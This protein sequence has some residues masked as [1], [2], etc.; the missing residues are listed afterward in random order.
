[1]AI[2]GAVI[3]AAAPIASADSIQLGSFATGTVAPTG[4]L[5]T[6]MNYA[7]V[8]ASTTPTS[9]TGASYTLAPGTVW[10]APLPNS[11]WVGYAS[12]AY[13]GGV[14]P[15]YGYYTFTTLFS[16]AGGTYSG[17]IDVMA[18]DTA[19]VLLNGNVIVPFGALGSDSHCA[20]GQ[21]D[22]LAIDPMALTGILL[23]SGT[24][25]NVLTFVVQQ[26]GLEGTTVDPSG[27]DFDATL[28]TSVTTVPEPNSLDLLGTGLLGSAAMLWL[29]RRNV[30]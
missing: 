25:N 5:N 20:G 7:G 29:F 9:G 19:E 22:C 2:L 14:N 13:P 28:A 27:V 1:L 3:A 11:A 10:S 23:N 4:D 21:P 6:A 15:P 16:A 12:T 8:S 26:A 24:D 17:T 18:D 30:A